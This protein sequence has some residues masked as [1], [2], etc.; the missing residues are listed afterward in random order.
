M[1]TQCVQKCF[2][3]VHAHEDEESG[4]HP[5]EECDEET[6]CVVGCKHGD[7]DF[8][9]EDFGKLGVSK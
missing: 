2:H 6:D 7:Q 9:K 1:Q 3:Q 4:A 8:I 5:D